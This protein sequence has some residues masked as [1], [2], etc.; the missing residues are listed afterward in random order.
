M[1]GRPLKVGGKVRLLVRARKRPVGPTRKR[2]KKKYYRAGGRGRYSLKGKNS[3]RGTGE[4]AFMY[5]EE[6]PNPASRKEKRS[7]FP[8]VT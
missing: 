7:I 1:E 8:V 6:K 4:E 3:S 2:K 5:R